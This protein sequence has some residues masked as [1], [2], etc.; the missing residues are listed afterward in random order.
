LMIALM[1]N[2]PDWMN[3]CQ[4]IRHGSACIDPYQQRDR[5]RQRHRQAAHPGQVGV[6]AAGR[7]YSAPGAQGGRTPGKPRQRTATHSFAQ[8]LQ[9]RAAIYRAAQDRL[10]HRNTPP[11]AKAHSSCV[12][13]HNPLMER[14]HENDFENGGNCNLDLR[15]CGVV[16]ARLV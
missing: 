11:I 5:S 10:I 2:L 12:G 1:S 8:G 4:F 3:I 13:R 9:T 15:V 6:E 7:P 16:V 14:S